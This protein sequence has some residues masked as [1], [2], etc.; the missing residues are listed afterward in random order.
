M[1]IS[2][3]NIILL[4][5]LGLH[6]VLGA[7]AAVNSV[8][9]RLIGILPLLLGTWLII[10][11]K[12]SK[13]EAIYCAAYYSSLEVLLRVTGGTLGYE[14]G[15]YALIYFLILGQYFRPHEDRRN[16]WI[17]FI[18]LLM[19]GLFLADWSES[20]IGQLIRMT[21]S[22]PVALAVCAYYFTGR[23]IDSIEHKNIL[24]IIVLPL[25]ALAVALTVRTPDPSLIDFRSASNFAASGGFGPV[26][27]SSVLGIGI[28]II[29]VSFFLNQTLFVYKIIDFSILALLLYRALLTFS[30]SGIYTAALVVIIMLILMLIQRRL[31]LQSKRFIVTLVVSSVL[32]FVIW[33]QVNDVTRGMAFNRYTGRNSAGVRLEDISSNRRMLISQEVKMFSDHFLLGIGVGMTSKIRR[34]EFSFVASSHTEYTRLMAE[35]GIAGL[36]MIGILFW[37]PFR[38]FIRTYDLNRIYLAVFAAYPLILMFTASTRTTLPLFLYGFSFLLV[39][40]KDSV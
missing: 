8:I 14:M 17:I 36:I 15:K 24:R 40:P 33:N 13:G 1:K 4:S 22:G 26:H 12:N 2:K 20:N 37:V 19:L 39:N 21:L 6:V 31:R 38:Q 23:E 35:H 9:A 27:V 18:I 32:L 29:M 30:R 7:G 25:F 28:L 3:V 11:G 34:E 16:V 10:R 5:L